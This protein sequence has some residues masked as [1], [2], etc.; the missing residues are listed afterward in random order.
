M[1]RV[2]GEQKPWHKHAAGSHLGLEHRLNDVLGARAQSQTH[3]VISLAAQQALHHAN[4]ASQAREDGVRRKARKQ[5]CLL[6]ERLEHG[7]ASLK[8]QH[9]S[10]HRAAGFV[11][12]AVLAKDADA[13]QRVALPRREIVRVVGGRNLHGTRACVR[14]MHKKI[15]TETRQSGVAHRKTCPQAPRR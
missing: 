7:H 13:R 8:A 4:N 3:G 5:P 1:C 2:S 9:A 6:L 12:V 11:D 14:K 15:H 10:E